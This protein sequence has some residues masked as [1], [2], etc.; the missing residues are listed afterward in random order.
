ML[1]KQATADVIS[2]HVC[3]V[4]AEVCLLIKIPLFVEP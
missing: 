3:V 1:C 2:S 4:A